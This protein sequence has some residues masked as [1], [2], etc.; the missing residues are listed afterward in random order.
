MAAPALSAH[1]RSRKPSA[2]RLAQIEFFKRTDGVQAVN[3]AIGNV[4][5][6][7]HPAL[8]RRLQTLGAPGSPF[9]EG[10]VKY[11]ATVGLTEARNAVLNVI[12]SSGLPI[13]NL[14][15][16]MTDGGSAA[17]ELLIVGVCGPA[18][19][20]ERPLL[21]VDAAYTNY[22]ALAERTGR[23]TVSVQ[24]TLSQDGKF[25]LPDLT[26]IE[27][28]IQEHQPGALVV[29]PYDNPTG[30]YYDH[31]TMVA[32]GRLCTRYNLWMASDEA[33]R[34][35]Y[36]LEGAPSS[37]WRI[38]EDDVP[39]I[40][41]RRVSIETASKVWNACGLR[42]GALVTDSA[43]LHGRSVAEFTANLC[44]NVVGQH[45]FAGLAEESHE[46]L[47]RWYTRQREYYRGIMT[48]VSEDLKSA[49]P[50]LVVSSPDA[51][52]YSVIDVE[53]V[54]KP[55]FDA[56]EFVLYCAREGAVELE[57]GPFTLL[58]S[59]M[60]GF[61]QPAAGTPNPGRTQMRIAYVEPPERMALVPRLFTELFEEYEHR[62]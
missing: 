11:S 31:Q 24:R 48:G 60:A 62:R 32:L 29:I 16:Q 8:Q 1:F 47:Q 61:Y 57:K 52:I 7:M 18:G 9:A 50:G 51:S 55:G 5:L 39:G 4:S 59:P 33:Y 45:I 22:K 15:V 38:S 28:T 10:V 44:A 13:Q 35:L 23:A 27:A 19:S 26:Q 12:A 54:A 2:I 20:S 53:D 42:V 21:L 6:P 41:G 14:H 3:T 34:E 36:Y 49:V 40:T 30:H 43:E 46:E 58:V 56:L 25:S 37:I 17:M